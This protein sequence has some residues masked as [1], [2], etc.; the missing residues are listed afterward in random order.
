MIQKTSK[1]VQPW[2]QNGG[3]YFEN[4]EIQSDSD[5]KQLNNNVQYTKFEFITLG[6]NTYCEQLLVT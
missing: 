4:F 5:S 1:A 3:W 2:K 6:L